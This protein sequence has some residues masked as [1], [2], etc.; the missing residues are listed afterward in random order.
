MT[1]VKGRLRDEGRLQV[2]L[3]ALPGLIG[4]KGRRGRLEDISK[5]ERSQRTNKARCLQRMGK[6]EGKVGIWGQVSHQSRFDPIMVW[7]VEF[8]FSRTHIA[9]QWRLRAFWIGKCCLTIH[10]S[11]LRM[12]PLPPPSPKSHW[13][14]NLSLG[15]GT[16]TGTQPLVPA[17]E[18]HQF[19]LT[20]PLHRCNSARSRGVARRC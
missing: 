18:L 17:S 13:T 9:G 14:L 3:A 7:R 12:T 16:T 20:A 6:K 15:W 19:Q 11:N 2:G 1:F 4:L 5:E 10:H 8:S